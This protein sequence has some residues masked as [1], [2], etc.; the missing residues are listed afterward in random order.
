MHRPSHTLR[1]CTSAMG[2]SKASVIKIIK[3]KIACDVLQCIF[4]HVGN[5]T[6]NFGI[7]QPFIIRFSSGFQH[8]DKYLISLLV[9]QMSQLNISYY[10]CSY[11]HCR[12]VFKHSIV[13]SRLAT[14]FHLFWRNMRW[15]VMVC[16]ASWSSKLQENDPFHRSVRQCFSNKTWLQLAAEYKSCSQ[17]IMTSPDNYWYISGHSSLDTDNSLPEMCIHP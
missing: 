15:S 13:S 2:C 11:E 16:D 9:T 14:P 10:H 8:D 4:Q 3:I 6:P 1:C 17:W 12:K 5:F 7:S